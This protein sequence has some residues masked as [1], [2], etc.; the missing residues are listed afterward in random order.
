[1]AVAIC[2]ACGADMDWVDAESGDRVPLDKHEAVGPPATYEKR[3]VVREGKAVPVA[4]ADAGVPSRAD[5][6]TTCPRR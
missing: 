3:Y 6:R 4:A 1:M 5:H 2:V